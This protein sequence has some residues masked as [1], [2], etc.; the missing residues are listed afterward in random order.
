MYINA[1]QKSDTTLGKYKTK[2]N[3]NI[4]KIRAKKKKENPKQ[5]ETKAK[6]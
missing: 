6:N 1:V 5:N 4:K 2:R 3:A